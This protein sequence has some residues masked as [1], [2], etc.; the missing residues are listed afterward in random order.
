[1]ARRK[2]STTKKA[3]KRKKPTLSTQFKCPFCSH[4]GSV[5][6]RLDY[7]SE[8]GSLEC[9]VCNATYSCSINYLSEPIDIFSE[10][11]DQ[12]E[13]EAEQAQNEQPA[14]D[15]YDDEFGDSRRIRPR[16]E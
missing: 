2:K 6:A 8:V 11:I 5:E 7:D 13:A 10:W 12:C 14:D 16:L 9:R 15:E 3:V 1:M 4:E